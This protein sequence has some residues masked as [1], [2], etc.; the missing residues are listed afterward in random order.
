MN[1]LVNRPA[2]LLREH[3]YQFSSRPGEAV[4]GLPLD[5]ELRLL[6]QERKEGERFGVVALLESLQIR[7]PSLDRHRA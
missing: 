2:S 3:V 7:Y 4:K 6:R 1:W 5:G